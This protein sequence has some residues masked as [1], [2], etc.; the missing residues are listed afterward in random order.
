[1][2]KNISSLAL[3]V[4]S[5]IGIVL[6]IAFVN[7]ILLGIG[8]VVLVSSIALFFLSDNRRALEQEDVLNRVNIALASI[9]EQA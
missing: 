6:G 1:M 8:T 3:H 2:V 9:G 4:L 7:P 5:F